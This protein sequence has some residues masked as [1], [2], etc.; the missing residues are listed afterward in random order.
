MKVRKI[1]KSKKRRQSKRIYFYKEY[2]KRI[3]HENKGI[4]EK[5]YKDMLCFGFTEINISHGEPVDRKIFDAPV[6]YE[7]P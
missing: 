5:A 4:F 6:C 1:L 2:F 7:K 3:A